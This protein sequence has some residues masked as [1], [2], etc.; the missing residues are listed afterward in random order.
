MIPS[1]SSSSSLTLSHTHTH[2]RSSLSGTTSASNR[3]VGCM[4]TDCGREVSSPFI[5][6][7]VLSSTNDPTTVK[8]NMSASNPN[9]EKM[10]A[11][12]WPAPTQATGYAFVDQPR[13]YVPQWGPS[14]HPTNVSDANNTNGYDY[15]N[16]VGGDTYIFLF[17]DQQV[18]SW[19]A[20]RKEFLMLTGPVRFCR[21]SCCCSFCRCFFFLFTFLSLCC[22]CL[23]SLSQSRPTN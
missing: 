6:I 1:S 3:E 13:F 10:N 9:L 20:S 2:T 18:A 19:H 17:H 4:S 16:N 23:S 12:R 22:S 21:C 7:V 11:L 14:P 5:N 8:Y 15:S